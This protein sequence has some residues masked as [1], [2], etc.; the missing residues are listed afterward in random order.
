MSETTW[1]RGDV[2]ATFLANMGPT[3]AERDRVASASEGVE[4]LRSLGPSNHQACLRAE[5][6]ARQLCTEAGV[7]LEFAR[8]GGTEALSGRL[9]LVTVTFDSGKL[10]REPL[11]WVSSPKQ[12]PWSRA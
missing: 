3:R 9:A 4:E 6:Q 5:G 12:G 8:I 2:I 1:E 10:G 11:E 7:P